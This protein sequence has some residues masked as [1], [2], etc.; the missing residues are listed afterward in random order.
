MIEPHEVGE[1]AI[2]ELALHLYKHPKSA[3]KEAV[4]NGLDEQRHK[5][6]DETR[7]EISTHVG[8]DNDIWIE[9]FGFGII[10]YAK[11]KKYLR[12][13]KEVGSTVS[14]YTQ[15]DPEIVGNK[16]VGKLGFLMLAGGD[17]PA[18]EFWSH[19]PRIE[20]E[21]G[22]GLQITMT[23]A[24]F[25]AKPMNSVDALPHPGVR[26]VIKKARYELLPRESDLIKYLSEVFAIRIRRGTKIFLDGNR[27]VHPEGF[28]SKEEELF[29]LSDGTVLVGNIRRAEKSESKNIW[30]FNKTILVDT[31]S[32]EHKCKGWINDNLIVPTSSREGIEDTPRW[33]EIQDKLREYLDE[34]FEKPT[35]PKIGR[36]GREKD[37]KALLIK[38]LQYRDHLLSGYYDA[39]GVYGEIMGG[40]NDKGKLTKKEN[41][42]LTN[43][44]DAED[45]PVIPI[46]PGHRGKGGRYGGNGK[47]P[48]Y[49]EG[50]D[51]T[52]LTG[53]GKNPRMA[54]GPVDPDIP[55]IIAYAE[56]KIVMAEFAPNGTQFI[57]NTY[58]PQT[59]KAHKA[60]GPDWM[61]LVAPVYAQAL[62]NLDLNTDKTI[63]T[64]EDWQKRYAVY[65]KFLINSETSE[66]KGVK[67]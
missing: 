50:G 5:P 61:Y 12:G 32:F 14:S 58:Y 22:L 20:D 33:L 54:H 67:R 47:K 52:I 36:M 21:P 45:G 11:F 18:V 39:K 46:G 64:M 56:D 66:K 31:M 48:G 16:G 51:Q 60:T 65:M 7:V 43:T 1:N 41:V 34:H 53:A 37:K 19:K 17:N 27:I 29:Q 10:N 13:Y 28:N 30:V 25:D 6:R 62:T 63:I 26:V 15:I 42:K 2:R 23:F 3:I 44:G 35:M 57:W 24:G 59:V 38:G 49:E 40:L 55:Q 9:D 4:T 8:P